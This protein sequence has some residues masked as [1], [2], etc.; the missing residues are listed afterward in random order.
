MNKKWEYNEVDENKVL[1]ISKKYNISELLATILVS[2]NIVEDEKVKVFLNP[3]RNDFYD[4]FLMPDMDIAVDRIIKAINKNERIVIY[5]DYDVDGITSIAVLKQFLEDRGMKVGYHIPNR[6]DEGY[7]LNTDAIDEIHNLGYN[8][9]ITVDCGISGIDEVEYANSLGI[10]TIIT[11]HH[12]PLDE[13]PNAIAI[14]DAKIKTN[15]YPFNQLAGVGVVFKLIQAIGIKLNLEEKEYLKYLDLVCI[16]TISDIVPLVDENRVIAKLGLLLVEKT[17]NLG[18]KTLLDSMGYQ[19]INSMSVSFGVAPRINACGRMGHAEEALKLFLTKDKNEAIELTNKLNDY[20]KT[21]QDIEKKIFEEAL[22]KIE[23]EDINNKNALIISGDNWHHG[24]IGIVSSKITEMYFKPSILIC[25]EGEKGKGSGRSIPGFDL[26]KALYET[27]SYLTKYGG[28]AM[29]VGL[30]LNKNNF[31]SFK[32]AFEKY[33][34]NSNISEIVPIINIDKLIT[35]K[36]LNIE[37]IK[38]LDKLEPYG[39]ANKCPLI[40]YKNL[41]I[42]SIRVLTEGKHMKLTLKMENNS[43]ISVMGFNMGYR[44]EEFL[45]GDKVDVVGTLEINSFNGMENVQINLKDIMKSI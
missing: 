18:L 19:K 25:F 13:L 37:V 3:T 21:R 1:E 20:N 12:E 36:D 32:D 22:D 14:M 45:I 10:E 34:D 41:K 7:G 26:H 43:I 15:K 4:P 31:S 9:M 23:N 38:E 30:S 27:S 28:H 8:L 40:A 42:D 16:G 35:Y 2:R 5:G 29:A 33:V 24:V 11:D 17:R 44:A 6:L 39:E